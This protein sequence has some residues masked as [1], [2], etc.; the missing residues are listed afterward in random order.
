MSKSGTAEV[1][2]TQAVKLTKKSGGETMTM[3]VASQGKP[4]ILKVTTEGGSKPE[5]TTFSDYDQKVA[6]EQP[7]AGDTVDLKELAAQ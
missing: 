4:Y 1:N 6:P 3:Y 7:P 2:G 5:S